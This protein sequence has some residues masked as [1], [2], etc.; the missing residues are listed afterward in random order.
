MRVY[1]QH[2]YMD[3]RREALEFWARKIKELS[4]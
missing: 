4:K 3:E 1:N 2:D